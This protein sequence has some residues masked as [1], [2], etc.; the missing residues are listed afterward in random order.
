MKQK[1][2]TMFLIA[3]CGILAVLS[4]LVTTSQDKKAPVITIGKNSA[5]ITYKKGEDY[6]AL[7]KGVTAEDN[8][9]G[10]MTKHIFIDSITPVSDG[11]KAIVRYAV[12]DKS[13]NVG[14]KTRVVNYE[15][16]ADA[17]QDAGLPDET[18]KKIKEDAEKKA[19]HKEEPA[20]GNAGEAEPEDKDKGDADKED[21]EKDKA[22]ETSAK[23]EEQGELKPDGEKPAIRLKETTRTIRAGESFDVLSVVDQV[24][25]DK[26]DVSVLSR[27]IHADGNYNTSVP[28]TYTIRY[29]VTDSNRNTS[30]V[31]EFKLIV[32]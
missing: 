12:I 2:L 13:N 22:E 8:R 25:D 1:I 7:L 9:D 17:L 19:E 24:V 11:K 4:F 26:D 30:D 16:G 28:G 14:V 6:K 31:E 5:D 10:D 21:G 3:G 18:E 23:P 27:R 15:G 20:E 32:K 29:Y